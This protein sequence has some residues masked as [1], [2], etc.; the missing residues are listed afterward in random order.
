MKNIRIDKNNDLLDYASELRRNM[1]PQERHLWY[2]FLRDFE[3][4]VYKQRIL[5]NFIADFYCHS[6]R[7]VIEIDGSQHYTTEGRSYDEARTE[8]IQRYGIE[9]I[10]FANS[11]VDNNFA[12]VCYMIEKKI[13]ERIAVL[14][15]E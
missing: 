6:A 1:T 11:D 15:E 14:C 7:L 8:I 2:D 12:G 9:V 3:I 5:G 13:R 4:N 10:R